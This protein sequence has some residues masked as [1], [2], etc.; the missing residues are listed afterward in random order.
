MNRRNRPRVIANFA[1][2]ADGKIS[3]R[4]HTPANFTSPRDKKRLLEIRARGDAILVGRNTVATDTM[5]MTL[6]DRALRAERRE[7]GLPAEPSRVIVSAS[8]NLDPGWKV[9][10]SRG[11]PR[12]VFSTFHMPDAIRGALVPLCDLHLLDADEIP[13]E[14]VLTALREIYDV[15]TLVCEG[16][17]TIFRQLV[18]LDAL[19][20]LHLTVAPRIFGGAQAPTLTGTH[21]GFLASIRH[22]RLESLRTHGEE[23]YLRYRVRRP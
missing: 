18:E 7:R 13:L 9:F 3:T 14:D 23:C 17:P 15:R 2:T 4:E 8:G 5:S 10:T 16:G 6:P 20:E 19:D 21:P 12:I 22:L 11:A 1:I